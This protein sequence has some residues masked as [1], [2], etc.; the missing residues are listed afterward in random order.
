MRHTGVIDWFGGY[1]RNKLR[2][3][4][5]YIKC[6]D[7]TSIYVSKEQICY[8]EAEL[9][10]RLKIDES[11]LASHKLNL[12]FSNWSRGKDPDEIEWEYSIDCKNF[13]PISLPKGMRVAFEVGVNADKGKKEAKS[14][15]LLLKRKTAGLSVQSKA[16]KAQD[17]TQ[18]KNSQL[19]NSL[20]GAK[21]NSSS[22]QIARLNSK[23]FIYC[24][25]LEDR[26]KIYW[27][28]TSDLTTRMNNHL[29]WEVYSTCQEEEI[30]I[31]YVVPFITRAEAIQA[32]EQAWSASD[33]GIGTNYLYAGTVRRMD[34]A[35]FH[36]ISLG[37]KGT[38]IRLCSF[39]ENPNNFLQFWDELDRN[40]GIVTSFTHIP[41]I[42]KIEV[43]KLSKLNAKYLLCYSCWLENNQ[44]VSSIN[45]MR[46]IVEYSYQKDEVLLNKEELLHI[47]AFQTEEEAN[48]ALEYAR[49]DVPDIYLH[50]RNKGWNGRRV[51]VSEII[52][53]IDEIKDKEN[54]YLDP[55]SSYSL[56]LLRLT[57]ISPHKY[58][59]GGSKIRRLSTSANI[60]WRTLIFPQ[61]W[62]DI[63]EQYPSQN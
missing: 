32:E 17:F 33:F 29:D 58:L 28:M 42:P 7:D 20:I 63:Y 2:K 6:E 30:W 25:Y 53:A 12:D 48:K 4:F 19:T 52:W 5:G 39:L 23:N 11:V 45:I 41:S 46:D 27:G 44:E 62:I 37:W 57:I 51:K 8:T 22:P 18:S 47:E 50:L 31:L 34:L 1:D 49:Y 43:T 15:R 16:I 3:K 24:L 10:E 9:A 35:Y 38:R 36:L 21:N 55:D 13:Y 60:D 61:T 59:D 54:D 26:D 40:K 14:I 56:K